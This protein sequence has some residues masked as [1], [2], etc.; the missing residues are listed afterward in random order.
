[1]RNLKAISE[2]GRFDRRIIVCREPKAAHV[3]GIDIL[4]A[5]EF[6][7]RLWNDELLDALSSAA[8]MN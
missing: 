2:E 5:R 4:P 6:V 7:E 8:L 1:L 3:D